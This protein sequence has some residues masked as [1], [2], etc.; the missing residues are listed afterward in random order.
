[1]GGGGFGYAG[2]GQQGRP[3]GNRHERQYKEA[4][5]TYAYSDSY[6]GEAAKSNID[7]MMKDIEKKA[8]WKEIEELRAKLAQF[9]KQQGQNSENLKKEEK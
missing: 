7:D 1:M 8:M 6:A 9:E 4:D 2:Y 5:Y 3:F